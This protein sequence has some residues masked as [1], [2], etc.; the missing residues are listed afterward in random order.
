MYKVIDN[1]LSPRYFEMIQRE[2][3]EGDHI[4]QYQGNVTKYRREDPGEESLFDFGFNHTILFEGKSS[5]LHPFLASFYADLLLETDTQ[6]VVRCRLDMV[7]HTPNKHKHPPHIDFTIHISHQFYLTNSDAET[8][9]YNER[10]TNKKSSM[11]DFSTLTEMVRVR[12]GQI[13]C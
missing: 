9:L 3:L 2:V 8:V 13:E 10:A 12:P 4:W 11:L 7:T 1:F 5:H 6:R